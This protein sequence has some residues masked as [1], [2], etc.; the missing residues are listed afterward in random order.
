MTRP[1]RQRL[2]LCAGS[3]GYLGY[4]PIASGTVSVLVLGIP[5]FFMMH[6][7]PWAWYLAGWLAFSGLAIWLS[8]VGDRLLGEKDS[9]KMVVDEIA[10]YLL[11]V[12]TLP[13]TWQV[14]VLSFVL[15][16]AIDIAKIFPANVIEKRL[17]GGWGVVLDDLVAGVY[18]LAIM[19]L[20]LTFFPEWLT[21]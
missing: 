19:R 7:L 2:I 8:G 13:F 11:A 21:G 1:L 6:R 9:S 17:P 18:T 12:F 3:L 15:E 16:R 10:G 5:L 20:L 14:V 4:V